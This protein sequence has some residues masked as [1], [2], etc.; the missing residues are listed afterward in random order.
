MLRRLLG[1][2]ACG[3]M[4]SD[5]AGAHPPCDATHSSSSGGSSSRVVLTLRKSMRA[6]RTEGEYFEQELEA[7]VSLLIA[8]V[9][10]EPSSQQAWGLQV[11]HIRAAAARGPEPHIDVELKV[12]GVS[13][14]VLREALAPEF[15]EQLGQLGSVVCQALSKQ[16]VY[17]VSVHTWAAPVQV[18]HELL[19][20]PQSAVSHSWLEE[21]VWA[22]SESSRIIEPGRH[23]SK[24][25]GSHSD[26]DTTGGFT[27]ARDDDVDEVL[28]TSIPRRLTRTEIGEAADQ[29]NVRADE[30]FVTA[31]GEL[32]ML[33]SAARSTVAT[34]LTRSIS[35]YE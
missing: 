3:C 17:P 20:R 35:A 21:P 25:L 13:V 7:F 24:T 34:P 19:L 2:D 23:V 33:S 12:D 30:S 1:V 4:S 5:V 27:S 9:A 16:L 28:S 18:E 32:S 11:L 14:S 31:R 6:V 8:A 15:V 22:T 26:E 29:S 10:G